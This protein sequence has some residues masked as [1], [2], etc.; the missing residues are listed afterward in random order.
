[1]TFCPHNVQVIN[2]RNYG[3]CLSLTVGAQYV[4][5]ALLPSLLEL[6]MK[7]LIDISVCFT[8]TAVGT[9]DLEHM[10]PKPT[11]WCNLWIIKLLQNH[12]TIGMSCTADSLEAIFIFT[13]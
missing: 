1:M 9:S 7:V 12:Y 4:F 10:I 13:T 5:S 8:G 2:I 3:T 11:D 6:V